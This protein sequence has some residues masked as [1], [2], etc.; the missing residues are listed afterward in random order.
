MRRGQTTISV[1][2]LPPDS[3][4]REPAQVISLMANTHTKQA[5]SLAQ[6]GLV[7]TAKNIREFDFSNL[8]I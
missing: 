1:R 3:C 6:V 4:C 5:S 7:N 8:F 2:P